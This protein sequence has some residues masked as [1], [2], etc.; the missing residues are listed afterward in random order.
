MQGFY[1]NVPS[2]AAG[3]ASAPWWWDNLAGQAGAMRQAGFTAVWIPPCLKGA[4]GGYSNGYDPFDD[5]D[6]GS[7]YQQGTV[8]TRYGTREQLERSVAVMRANG[9]DVLADIVDNHRSGDD[10]YFNFHYND[11]YGNP[12]S[13]RFQKGPG[14]FHWSRTN[15]PEDADVPD[16]A[17][18]YAYQFGRDLAPINGFR[19]PDGAGYAFE[20]L[21]KSGDWLTKALDIQGY[22]L[23][24]VKGISTNFLLP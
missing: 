14:D 9:L 6:L 3:T 22:R 23:D 13:G 19:G 16:P 7:K 15:L 21:E 4:A 17:A 8:T 20:G 2:P 1:T 5:Y 24:D 10:G 11:A 18:D 12:N